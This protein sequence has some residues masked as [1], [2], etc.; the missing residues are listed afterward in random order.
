MKKKFF[1]LLMAMASALSTMAQEYY[2][3]HTARYKAMGENCVT[4]GGFA[5]LFEGW[6]NEQGQ[7]VNSDVWAIEPGAGPHS[8]NTLISLQSSNQEGDAFAG[9]W[10]LEQGLYIISYYIKAESPTSTSLTVG[11]SNYLDVY[12]NSDGTMAYGSNS[13]RVAAAEPIG[14]E[15]SQVVCVAQ[16]EA[17][18][19][20]VFVASQ[21]A[22]GTQIADI[23]IRQA[24]QVYDTRQAERLVAYAQQLLADD[25]LTENKD[26]LAGALEGFILP[27]LADPT[28]CDDEVSMNAH[29]EMFMDEV[30]NP[31]LDANGA[32]L[33]GTTL[34]DWSTWGGADYK[35]MA[36]RG[37]WT[38]DGGRW[39]FYPNA[40]F[41]QGSREVT[42]ERQEGDGYLAQ[43]G[44]QTGMTLE[45]SM[46]TAAGA[47]DGLPAGKYF[48]SIEAQAVAAAN[49]QSP[50]GGNHAIAVTGATISVGETDKVLSDTLSG[51]YWKTC[52]LIADISEGQEKKV[53]FSFPVLDGKVG[54]KFAL[55]NPQVRQL[56][57]STAEAEFN[58]KKADFL[59]QQYNLGL[60][61]ANYPAE[62]AGYPW[63]KDSLQ[64]ALDLAQ[65]V[66]DASLLII[67]ANGTV[68]DRSM[69][70]DEQTQLM[71]AEVNRL[72]RAR[73]YIIAQNA[74]IDALQEALASATAALASP[75]NGSAPATYRTALEDAVRAGEALMATLT[76][77]NQGPAFTEAANKIKKAQ[78]EFEATAA[79]RANPTNIFI[80]NADFSD[81]AVNS[82]VT[83]SGEHNGWQWTIGDG[84]GR[85]EIRDN[86]T[87]GKGH[88]ATCWRGTTAGPNGRVVQQAELTYEG[89]YE[90][91]AK[92]YISEERINELVAAAEV[93]YDG[94][95]MPIDTIYKPGI[96][97][98]FGEEGA[99][100][101]ITISKCY[102]GVKD[103]GT[104]FERTSDGKQYPGMVYATYSVFF[105]KQGA[106]ATRVEFGLEAFGNL[107]NAG[108]NGFGFG[109]N[110]LL[111]LGNEQQYLEDTR[112][113]LNSAISAA[114]D[115]NATAN[116]YWG[117][118]LSRYI[119]D[120]QQATTA[121]EMQ[122]ALHG[123]RE[124]TSRLG[125]SVEGISDTTISEGGRMR[126]GRFVYDIQGRLLSNS[127]LSKGI[128]IIN[129]KKHIVR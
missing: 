82:N 75:A 116:N 81:F 104:Y 94:G 80:S 6:T 67:D 128:Y 64:R 119:N 97:L 93:V 18:D 78:E 62:L 54:G 68:L 29:I 28:Q 113:D 126:S 53:G 45:A 108:A 129:G 73:S 9:V 14:T 55:R 121:K 99:P 91:R 7:S 69:V 100:D 19:Q 114:Q 42:L 120:A 16:I 44:I 77:E 76:S 52:Y 72:G 115:V 21:M 56:G 47:L 59:V 83:A 57:V 92:A 88:G 85:W 11:G 122:N 109:D 30:F 101:S 26:E 110:Q 34:T 61:L 22:T 107:A 1:F 96:R 87:L 46:R 98:F 124:V 8:E 36:N 74:P 125:G 118:K 58:K 89:L 41:M 117:T 10:T 15:W 123:M 90:Y 71:L 4:N 17:G 25:N 20:L 79:S 32:N 24:Q 3:T 13:V 63:E 31:F 106:G 38:F 60:R 33:V 12:V 111:Y 27:L 105:C 39:G 43:A 65:P 40:P 50:Y 102:M 23:E 5:Q 2:F 37:T 95:G 127:K 48:F 66:Y 112:A 35:A 49:R 84:M 103:D 70:N 86:E 51:Y